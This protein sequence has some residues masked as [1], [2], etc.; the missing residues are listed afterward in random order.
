MFAQPE[1]KRRASEAFMALSASGAQTQ[2]HSAPEASVQLGGVSEPQHHAPQPAPSAE[3]PVPPAQAERSAG[4]TDPA[5]MPAMFWDTLPE[6]ESQHPDKLAMDA[7]MEELTPAERA[8]NL[9]VHGALLPAFENKCRSQALSLLSLLVVVHSRCTAM[10]VAL[11][12]LLPLLPPIHLR[13]GS[14]HS[15]RDAGAG[16]RQRRFQARRA[17]AEEVLPQGSRGPVHAGPRCQQRRC[18]PGRCAVCQPC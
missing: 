8:A 4:G 6:G 7:M 18:G 15:L 2:A 14:G 10:D 17:A 9:K 3:A 5:A 13:I 11:L 12:A 16:A 1:P